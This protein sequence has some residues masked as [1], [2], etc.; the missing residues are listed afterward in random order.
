MLKR[1]EYVKAEAYLQEG[2]TIARRIGHRER[3]GALLRVLGTVA[4]QSRKL[5]AI[6]SLYAGRTDY[7]PSNRRP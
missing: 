4:D 6:G 5:S 2:L 3:I 1:G 7:C